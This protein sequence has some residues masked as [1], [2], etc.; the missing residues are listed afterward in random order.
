MRVECY[1][2]GRR[3]MRKSKL[4]GVYPVGPEMAKLSGLPVTG[5]AYT[6]WGYV[7][8]GCNESI[9]TPEQMQRKFRSLKKTVDKYLSPHVLSDV[10]KTLPQ[11]QKEW[12]MIHFLQRTGMQLKG[13]C[14]QATVRIILAVALVAFRKSFSFTGTDTKIVDIIRSRVSWENKS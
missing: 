2:C 14:D 9:L 1:K 13:D 11:D 10:D 6:Y 8:D 3:P 5:I 4:S 12:M 7:C